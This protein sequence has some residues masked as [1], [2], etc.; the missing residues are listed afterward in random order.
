MTIIIT[1]LRSLYA[2]ENLNIM[3]KYGQTKDKIM[4]N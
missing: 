4:Y 3:L 1:N 2:V